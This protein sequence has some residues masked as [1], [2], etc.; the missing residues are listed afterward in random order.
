MLKIFFWSLTKY[1]FKEWLHNFYIKEVVERRITS[2]KS[3][4]YNYGFSFTYAKKE[5]SL[6]NK[7][8]DKYGT[9]KGETNGINQPYDW[10]SHNYSDFYEILFRCRNKDVQLLIEC[11]LGTNNINV[12]SSMGINAKPGASLRMWRDY[13]PLARIVGVD[14]D[15]Q[16]LFQEERIDTYFCDQLDSASI[17]NFAMEANLSEN[18][19][20]VI[21]DDGL[22]VFDA[23]VSFFENMIRFLSED[24][25]CV[26][27]D[28][29]PED[30][31]SYKNYFNGLTNKYSINFINGN[32]PNKIF[33]GDNRLIM[34]QKQF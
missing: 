14:I 17:E 33:G 29:T 10:T 6:I 32:R 19:A 34:I 22:H 5:N 9:D 13:F 1:Y 15:R 2:Y 21:I 28:V 26:I 7:L 4:I 20:D 8:C 12:K 11:G 31:N 23:G 3:D 18:S 25:I 16:V 30:M 27:E 24:G